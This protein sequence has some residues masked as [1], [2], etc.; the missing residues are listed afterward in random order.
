[1]DRTEFRIGKPF[2]TATGRWL[3][4]DIGTRVITAIKIDSEDYIAGPPYAIVEDVFDE[5]DQDGCFL[6]ED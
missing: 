2:R 1:M 6:D 3:C 5:F 4:T